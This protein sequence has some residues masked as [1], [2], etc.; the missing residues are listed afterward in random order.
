[1]THTKGGAGGDI[2]ARPADQVFGRGQWLAH[3]Q[4]HADASGRTHGGLRCK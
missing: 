1:M 4:R 2:L 3:H